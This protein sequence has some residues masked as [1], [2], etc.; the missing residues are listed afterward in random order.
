MEEFRENFSKMFGCP[1]GIM[2]TKQ[3]KVTPESNVEYSKR[4]DEIKRSMNI[5]NKENGNES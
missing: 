4:V 5:T 2:F 3:T 1:E